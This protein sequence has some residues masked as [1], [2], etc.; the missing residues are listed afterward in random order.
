MIYFLLGVIF[1]IDSILIFLKVGMVM[2][3]IV[4]FV[5]Y[6]WGIEI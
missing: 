4:M 3:M 6:R 5:F 1:G 2:L